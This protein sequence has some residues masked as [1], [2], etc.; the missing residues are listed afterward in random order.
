[1]LKLI[2]VVVLRRMSN[3]KV[4]I[5]IPTRNSAQFLEKTLQTIKK[6]LYPDIETIIVDGNSTDKT[7]EISKKYK[8]KI[9]NFIPKVKIGLFDAPYKRNLGMKKATGAYVYWL[10]ADMELPKK[11]IQEAV[12]LCEEGFD[13]VVL[14][15]D[16]FGTGVWSNAK[17]LERRCYWNDNTVESPRFFKK[18]VWESIGGFDE[19]LGAGGDDVDLTQKLFEKGYKI[20]RVKSI[21]LN[22]EGNI[23]FK[24]LCKKKFMYGREMINYMVKRP[25]SS[26]ASYFPV[27]KAYLRNWR[28]L[29]SQPELTLVLIFM[30][31]AEYAAGLTGLTYSLF[32]GRTK[33]K[34]QKKQ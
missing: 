28:L 31:F 5:V 15:E 17:H 14:P 20:G 22:N 10:D 4:S 26:L 21:V 27:R 9:I 1:M 33:W 34:K 23:T 25:K 3:K 18:S 29:L 16:S 13:A 7:L 19:S 11:L 12:R 30:R 24:N 32:E 8:T 2:V 6:Q